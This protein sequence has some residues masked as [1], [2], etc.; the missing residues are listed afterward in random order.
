MR[1][2]C[3]LLDGERPLRLLFAAFDDTGPRDRT[4]NSIVLLSNGIAFAIQIVVF[5]ILGSFAGWYL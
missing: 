5:L 2:Y 3:I 4:V 1:E